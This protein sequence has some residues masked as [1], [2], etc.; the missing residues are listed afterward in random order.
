[1]SVSLG[2]SIHP[3]GYPF[4]LCRDG[5][6]EEFVPDTVHLENVV[7][8]RKMALIPRVAAWGYSQ[9]GARIEGDVNGDFTNPRLIAEIRDTIDY[10]FGIFES[11]C[12]TPVKYVR[13]VPPVGLTQIAELRI[14]EDSEMEREIKLSPVTDLPY[15]ENVVDGNILSHLYCK[16]DTISSPLVFEL[17][18]PARIDRVYYIPRTDDNYVWKGDAYELLYNDGVNGW[19]S[20]GT[21][22]ASGRNITFSA[23]KNALLWLRNKTKGKEEQ[24]FIYRNNRQWFNSDF[25]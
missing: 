21:R 25:I 10:T 19:K 2:S 9:I 14:Y 23:P 12:H 11:R 22:T 4:M 20:L 1:M 8:S 7:L 15:I 3:A 18:S 6:V 13:Y 16:T 17:D 24:V 5:H